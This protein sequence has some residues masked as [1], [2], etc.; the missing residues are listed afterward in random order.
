MGHDVFGVDN[1]S[2]GKSSNINPKIKEFVIADIADSGLWPSIPQVDAIFHLAALARIQ[3]SF[4]YPLQTYNANS[5]GTMHALEFA[6]ICRAKIVYPGSSSAYH[7]IY[8]N[9]Y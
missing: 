1:L 8:A 2:T 6:R 9:P 4:K 7:D 5:I 3:P